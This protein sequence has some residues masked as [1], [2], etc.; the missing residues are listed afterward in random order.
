MS[1]KLEGEDKLSKT[2]GNLYF[3][4]PE[5]CQGK[6]DYFAGKPVDIWAMGVTIYIVTF[7]KLPFLPNNLS[8]FLELFEVIS[9]GEYRIINY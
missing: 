4:P 8:N 1:S 6:S 7:Q 2:E 5:C 3:Y 9:K